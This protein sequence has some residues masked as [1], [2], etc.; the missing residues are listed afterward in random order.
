M[1]DGGGEKGM[2]KRRERKREEGGE[3][4]RNGGK[5]GVESEHPGHLKGASG[6]HIGCDDGHLKRVTVSQ[7][8]GVR[9]GSVQ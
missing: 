8:Q 7:C 1:E 9:S 6:V 2:S 4:M 5:G 3:G